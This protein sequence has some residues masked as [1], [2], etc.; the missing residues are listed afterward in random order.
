M[1]CLLPGA[2]ICQY[3]DKAERHRDLRAAVVEELN[4]DSLARSAGTWSRVGVDSVVGRGSRAATGHLRC[5]PV[6]FRAGF[7]SETECVRTLAVIVEVR[8][9]FRRLGDL[10]L[11]SRQPL[12]SSRRRAGYGLLVDRCRR[13]FA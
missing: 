3:V 4:G 7:A 5:L 8:L 9:E 10:F 6:G 11:T 1:D 2:F 13:W 12:T